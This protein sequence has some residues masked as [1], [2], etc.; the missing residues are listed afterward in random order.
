MDRT[1]N[2][3]K[4]ETAERAR[5]IIRDAI[6]KLDDILDNVENELDNAFTNVDAISDNMQLKLT[7]LWMR[8]DKENYNLFNV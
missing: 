7:R 1:I 6:V 3:E 4:L 8:Y 5:K 2:K